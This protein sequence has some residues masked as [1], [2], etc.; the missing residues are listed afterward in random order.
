MICTNFYQSLREDMRN[1]WNSTKALVKMHDKEVRGRK[2]YQ[3]TRD[4]NYGWTQWRHDY[5]RVDRT[6]RLP[7]QL[8]EHSTE[9]PFRFADKLPATSDTCKYKKS[10]ELKP[11]LEKLYAYRVCH[12]FRLTMPDD[13]FRVTCYQFWSKWYFLR[14]LGR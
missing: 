13:W 11:T 10:Y 9:R 2:I 4:V 3:N 5:L 1:F 12:G 7:S 6:P 14:Q 8:L